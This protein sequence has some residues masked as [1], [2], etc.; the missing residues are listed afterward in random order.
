ME[1]WDRHCYYAGHKNI[2]WNIPRGESVEEPYPRHFMRDAFNDA[3]IIITVD[4]E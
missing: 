4:L 2:V 3:D 1:K